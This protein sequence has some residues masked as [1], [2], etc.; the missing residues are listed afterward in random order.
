MKKI[1]VGDLGEFWYGDYKEPFEQLEGGV[2]GY[3]RGVVLRSDDERLLC[4]YCGKTWNDLGAHVRHGHGLSVAQYKEEV[5]L[6][7]KSALISERERLR[8]VVQATKDG[9][10]TGVRPPQA[11]LNAPRPSIRG[12]NHH[13]NKAET[14][15]KTGRCRAQLVEVAR[16]VVRQHGHLSERLLRR[17]GIHLSSVQRFF[18]SVADLEK[19]V[20]GTRPEKYLRRYTDTELLA[21]LR[22]MAVSLGRTPAKSDLRRLGGPDGV[23]YIRR[24]GSYPEACRQ[25]GLDPNLPVVMDSDLE[26]RILTAYATTGDSHS[27]ARLLHV[28]IPR[29]LS[30]LHRYGQPFPGTRR[31]TPDRR[32]WASEMAQRLA[33]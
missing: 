30:V 22:Q 20:G 13:V 18:P 17:R 4:A 27:V 32:H 8:R 29:V 15:N 24:F 31:F 23:T 14:L 7:K 2:P 1:A 26:V 10:L 25:A 28:S 11:S 12:Q 21:A 6:L 19:L 3:P 9:K 16:Q 5:G 33:A